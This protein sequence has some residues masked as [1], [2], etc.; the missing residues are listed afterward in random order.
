MSQ[1]P[2][3]PSPIMPPAGPRF[4][5][6]PP[7]AS[8]RIVH[9]VVRT[10][11]PPHAGQRR[12]HDRVIDQTPETSGSE[13]E[14]VGL[15]EVIGVGTGGCAET[16]AADRESRPAQLNAASVNVRPQTIAADVHMGRN[17]TTERQ[18]PLSTWSFFIAAIV[19]WPSHQTAKSEAFP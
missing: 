4:T 12:Y 7:P 16:V 9:V 11:G 2:P 13:P 15:G 8:I 10:V 18:L 3:A 14:T 19:P 5:L 6:T 17:M 1:P